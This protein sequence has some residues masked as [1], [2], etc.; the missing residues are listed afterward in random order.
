MST[1]PDKTDVSVFHPLYRKVKEILVA[2][3]IEG[4]WQPGE[5]IPSELDLTRE[6]GVSQGTVRKALS[7][8]AEEN[9]L[10]RQRGRG[11][12]VADPE[13]GGN[14]SRL[15]RIVA[16]SG[17]YSLP[18]WEIVRRGKGTAD[19]VEAT[20]LGIKPG[21]A[22]WLVDRK[23]LLEDKPVLVEK[24]TLPVSRAPG[25]DVLE[26]LPVNV[27]NLYSTHWGITIANTT[28]RLKAVKASA[29]VAELL[30]C[31]P[32]TAILQ[33]STVA[34]DLSRLPVELRVSRAL[35]ENVH[36]LSNLL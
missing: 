26:C 5:I 23:L 19:D 3:I 11:T 20:E 12:F 14:V 17:E 18:K 30:S 25:F 13:I 28:E 29:E 2:R 4:T 8:M 6:M 1:G 9:L 7:L 33:Y 16:D 10:V 34:F 15:F 21:S 24:I 27:Y 32:G 36:Y 22:V 31:K 35:T